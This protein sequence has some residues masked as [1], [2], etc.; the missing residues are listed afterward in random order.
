MFQT[1]ITKLFGIKYPIIQGGLQGLGKESLVIAVSNEGALGMLTAG[2]YKNKEEFKTAIRNVRKQTPNPFGVNI[3]I[4]IRRPMDE[5]VEAVIDE[6]VPIVFTSGQNPQPYMEKLKRAGIIVTHVV[7]SVRFAKKAET[8]GCDA[9]VVVGYECAGHPGL[10]DV[11]S[12]TLVQKA[13]QELN[14][15]VIAAGGFSTGKSLLAALALGAEGIQMGTRFLLS[16]ESPLHEQVKKQMVSLNETDT[17]I[18]KR[19]IQKPMRVMKT[20]ISKRIAEMEKNNCSLEEIFPYISG[21]SYEKLIREG[22]IGAGVISLGQTI[23]L[24]NNIKS[25]K[26]I[27]TSII[28]EA[29]LQLKYLYHL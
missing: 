20:E 1:K 22:D 7:P 4:G 26:E 3:T 17:L 9:V 28:E 24:I 21:E 5:F 15:P 25:V 6:E 14:I 16:K 13:V 12:L 23:G 18:I 10:D 2:S 27:I 8:I 19:S 11:T 29:E